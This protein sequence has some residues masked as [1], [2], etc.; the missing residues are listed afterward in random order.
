MTP[1]RVDWR[2]LITDLARARIKPADIA[3]RA[4]VTRPAIVTLRKGGTNP[5][6]QTGERLIGLWCETTGKDRAQLPIVIEIEAQHET[7]KT[8]TNY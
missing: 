5:L 7:V 3:A 6:H 1:H 4:G 2:E 8:L